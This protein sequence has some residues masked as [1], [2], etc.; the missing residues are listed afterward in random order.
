[1]KL[2][3]AIKA[4]IT[5]N[6]TGNADT[7]TKATQDGSGNVITNTYV[8]KAGDTMTGDLKFASGKDLI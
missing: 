4:N 5:G 6:L 3:S 7:A 2:P 1:M 8:K